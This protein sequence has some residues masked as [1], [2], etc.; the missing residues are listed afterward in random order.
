MQTKSQWTEGNQKNTL[1]SIW[2]PWLSTTKIE[3]LQGNE[4]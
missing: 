4:N 3:N 2:P 1:S